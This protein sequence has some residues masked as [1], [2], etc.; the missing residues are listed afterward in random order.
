MLKPFSLASLQQPFVSF[1][2]YISI[3]LTSF[4]YLGRKKKGFPILSKSPSITSCQLPR[5]LHHSMMDARELTRRS[6]SLQHRCAPSTSWSSKPASLDL[7]R[8]NIIKSPLQFACHLQSKMTLSA[9]DADLVKASD[10]NSQARV[11]SQTAIDS[12]K[13]ERRQVFIL[14]TM[15][16]AHLIVGR[17]KYSFSVS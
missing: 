10:S 3:S 4:I 12:D 2:F 1:F 17:V 15:R 7:Y 8:S 5:V 6:K 14:V 9:V 13:G 11:R 16:S